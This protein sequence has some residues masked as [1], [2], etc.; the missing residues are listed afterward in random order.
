M[1]FSARVISAEFG[2][3]A[4]ARATEVDSAIEALDFETEPLSMQLRPGSKTV[5]APL[6]PFAG[7]PSTP[8]LRDSRI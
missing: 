6:A 5:G 3:V 4:T 2:M 7:A 1:S 8:A